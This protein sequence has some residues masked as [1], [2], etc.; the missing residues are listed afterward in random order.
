M[1]PSLHTQTPPPDSGGG[2]GVIG[3]FLTHPGLRVGHLLSLAEQHAFSLAAVLVAT[4][5]AVVAVAVWV[6]RRRERR[7]AE[8]AR[9]V[10]ILVPPQVQPD[11]ATVLWE[12][13]HGAIARRWWQRWL[14][15]QHLLGFEYRISPEFGARIRLWV[16]SCVPP[17]LI[18]NA[19]TS[20]WRGARTHTTPA[21]PP[22]PLAPGGHR[23]L[24][25][26]GELR[27][28]RHGRWPIR[29]N[30]PGDPV[31]FL[32]SAAAAMEPGTTACVQV[33]AR[34]VTTRPTRQT[35][36]GSGTPAALGQFLLEAGRELF[37]LFAPGPVHRT[38]TPARTGSARYGVRDRQVSLEQSAQ[39]HAAAT[40][41]SVPQWATVVRY[42]VT[43]PVSL[44]ADHATRARDMVRGRAHAVSAFLSSASQHN[45][46]LRRWRRGAGVREAMFWRRL[47]R[48]D[49]L[50]S[51]ELA[52]LAHLPTDAG[53]AEIHRAGA[54]A[55]APSEVVAAGGPGTKPLGRADATRGRAVAMRVDDARH[56]V[57]VIGP[58][59]T[60]KSTLL[61]Q[62][63]LADAAARRGLVLV[64]PKGDLVSDVLTRLP[65]ECAG[66]VVL[67]DA[68]SASPPPCINPLDLT[69]V[70][71]DLDQA[72]DN[73]GSVF[74]RIYHQFWGPRTDDVF[75]N[76]LKT[77]CAQARPATLVD[78]ARLLTDDTYRARL[79]ADV[80][81]PLLQ[82][83]WGTFEALGES[84]RAQL[85][86][87]LLNKLR[88]LLMRPFVR[89]ALAGG[90]ATVDLRA[91]LDGGGLV[92][93]RLPKGRLGE[94]TT[95]L[96]GALLVA[97]TW[98][99][100]TARAD[101][102]AT[103]R[104][105]A[106]LYLDECHNF[107]HLSTPVE[108][109]LA[110]ARGLRL[111]MVLAHQNLGQLT[112]TLREA[113]S[114]NARNKI[115]FALSPEDSRDL[116]RHTLPQLGEH[117]LAHLDAYHAAARLIV[118]G[119]NTAPC[120][121]ETTPL[122]PPVPGRARRIRAAARAH[123]TPR[124]HALPASAPRANSSAPQVPRDDPRR[125]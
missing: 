88:Q 12:Q 120:T 67:F 57:H 46:Y 72:V 100:A 62:M 3:K 51:P 125:R 36:G 16:P 123:T 117:D 41:A 47:G 94:D 86:A 64:D 38:G 5:T 89:S 61:G 109:M 9:H 58:T 33:L 29:T 73:I 49:L 102:P 60:G 7:W 2:G 110:E 28:A 119:Q 45:H 37:G 98:Q 20:S 34:P 90:P 76:S 19:V 8:G 32:L 114:T 78:V 59:G 80:K 115:Y 101:T 112:P 69:T 44:D 54:R 10:E 108:D 68:D 6:R 22:L 113:I 71:G 4:V 99:A 91:A 50:S 124:P 17:H 48:G 53:I 92:L 35:A 13:L 74:G 75:R 24:L 23:N 52:V 118:N 55:L 11:G 96:F 103:Q 25:A 93:A 27:L 116:A 70:G 14:S 122:P 82:Q 111:S 1:T 87:P 83:F 42:A 43:A 30:A 106:A 26:G 65:E 31:A 121:V 39:D 97:R 81:D 84:G 85:I 63:V 104:R 40:K 77:V 18:E 66:R 21:T 56:H 107:L 95:R 15:G 79:T 105:D